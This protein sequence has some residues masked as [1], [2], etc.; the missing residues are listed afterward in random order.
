MRIE[1]TDKVKATLWWI[2]L[3]ASFLFLVIGVDYLPHLICW[4]PMGI[5]FYFAMQSKAFK[6]SFDKFTDRIC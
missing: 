6:K 2:A 1:L 4:I 5:V 3:V